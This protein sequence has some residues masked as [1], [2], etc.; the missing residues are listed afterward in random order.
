MGA[1]HG[2]DFLGKV[3]VSHSSEDK[4]FVRRLVR[5]LE[6]E[7]FTTWLDEKELKPGDALS[8]EIANALARARVVLV[9]VSRASVK[10]KWL[11][12]ELSLAT[13]RM[14]KGRCRVIPVVV[15]DVDPPPE[16]AGLL[17]ADFRTSFALG[18]KSVVTALQ[19]E[20][21]RAQ[22]NASF[23]V[24]ADRAVEK[25]FGGRSYVSVAGGYKGETWETVSVPV[26]SDSDPEETPVYYDS[27]SDYL[28]RSEPLDEHWWASFC[29]AVDR[30]GEIF[31]LILSER[32]V[33]FKADRPIAG[34]PRIA[35]RSRPI[36]ASHSSHAVV[37][38]MNGL[39][40]D[41]WQSHL[42]EA[43]RLFEELAIAAREE[44]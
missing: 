20:R 24:R 7:G 13:E 10:S 2:Q 30:T 39:P 23:Y 29:D 31:S 9:V 14:I 32:P 4:P 42:E 6:K 38:E 33:G 44:R 12:Y 18:A 22:Q 40:A 37:V 8:E 1:V 27:V 17:Y 34:Y 16:V 3:F 35:V 36:W 5:R 11:K 15:G 41:E 28:Q 21:G 26:P 43:R 19:Y 25:A